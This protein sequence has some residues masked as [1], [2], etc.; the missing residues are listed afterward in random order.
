[1]ER[2][3]GVTIHS[4]EFLIVNSSKL[5]VGALL[6]TC[7]MSDVG[8]PQCMLLQ[9]SFLERHFVL[10]KNMAVRPPTARVC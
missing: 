1:M 10:Y 3:G 8:D 4:I 5:D 7:W 6:D 9:L 2:H